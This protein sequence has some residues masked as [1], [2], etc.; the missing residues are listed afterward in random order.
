MNEVRNPTVLAIL[1]SLERVGRENDVLMTQWDNIKVNCSH[2]DLP[3]REPGDVHMDT[4][5]DCGFV[6]YC[7]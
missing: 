3:K 1:R 6:G 5:P 4:C 2:K 7:F